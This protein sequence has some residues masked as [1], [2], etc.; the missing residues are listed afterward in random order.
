MGDN[1]KST[2]SFR[3]KMKAH[4]EV[5]QY[6]AL[7]A[8]DPEN[9]RAHI[10]LAELY[11]R[12]GEEVKALK[13]Y[14]QA[15]L[16][17]ERKGFI[18]K[19]RAILRQALSM[20]PE[21]G[22]I[23]VLLA[24]I[25]RKDGLDRD[26]AIRYQTAANYYIKMGNKQAAITI[27]R[28]I[29]EIFPTNVPIS[30]KLG[31]LLVDQKMYQEALELLAPLAKKLK[32]TNRTNDYIAVLK[33]LYAATE[34]KEPLIALQ[35]IDAYIANKEYTK[36]LSVL[37]TVISS[38]PSNIEYLNRLVSI[39]QETQESNKLI[40]AYKQLASALGQHGRNAEK[41]AVY[42]KVL[43][44]DPQDREALE[45]L[46]QHDELRKIVNNKIENASDSE[47][48][49]LIE[50]DV[51]DDDESDILPPT[52]EQPS[53]DPLVRPSSDEMCT[54][55]VKEAVAFRTYSLHDKAI[56]VIKSCAHWKQSTRA[57]DQLIEIAI[58]QEDFI[59]ATQYMA[60]LMDL[61]LDRNEFDKAGELLDDMKEIGGSNETIIRY[62]RLLQATAEE[63]TQSQPIESAETPDILIDDD[64]EVLPEDILD[65]LA[66]E[67]AI[68]SEDV[69]TPSQE[70]EQA[71]N[72]LD[73][74]LTGIF[75]D[76]K[77]PPQSSLDELEFYI[78]IE[79]Y[80]SAGIL[81]QDLLASYP[82][83]TILSEMRETLPDSGNEN[84]ADTLDDVR[85]SLQQ[86]GD[87]SADE[88][89]DTGMM[90]RSMGMLPD[91]LKQFTRAKEQ[92]P[93][94]IKYRMSVVDTL[95]DLD[96]KE[97]AIEELQAILELSSTDE[98][99]KEIE[100]KLAELANR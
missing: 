64:D 35:L 85:S 51:D 84:L 21:H 7:I 52:H 87:G 47:D 49:I 69:V 44:L 4:S 81:L 97:R 20:D 77:E 63:P 5:E 99:R 11:A 65:D 2:L 32:Q 30:L 29:L 71:V 95:I 15:A 59:G 27:L 16:L 56:S 19:A 82:D 91:A 62:E 88:E 10:R 12:L 38:D 50:I 96:Q 45:S 72:K 83:S 53:G 92:D 36:A 80:E 23:N 86:M 74:L 55:E 22:R 75:D 54:K 14:E 1:K 60:H 48:D 73:D 90:F 43:E 39:F 31:F 98:Q 76:V 67:S 34:H 3:K 78:S 68:I 8:K 70:K 94:N 33:L 9:E 13:L 57:L 24:D 100:K 18:T 17:F 37:Q 79:D 58:E 25:D 28:K 89:Y 46:N 41:E 61:Y 93:A 40:A 6:E 66:E 26:A 42:Y